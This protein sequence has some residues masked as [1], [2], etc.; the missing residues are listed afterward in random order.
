MVEMNQQA[1]FGQH[2]L[3]SYP[4]EYRV[5]SIVTQEG[6]RLITAQ[7]W[8]IPNG[9]T[10]QTPRRE[11]DRFALRLPNVQSCNCARKYARSKNSL[12]D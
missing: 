10:P 8:T 11:L 4:I 3:E 12:S 6:C 9:F 2:D 7:Q 5:L 1:F